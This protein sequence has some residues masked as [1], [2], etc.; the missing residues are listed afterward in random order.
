MGAPARF[1]TQDL[2]A[3]GVLVSP[4]IGNISA[5]LGGAT[6]TYLASSAFG[7]SQEV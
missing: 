4:G 3:C 5:S 7:A 1:F 2:L 6:H